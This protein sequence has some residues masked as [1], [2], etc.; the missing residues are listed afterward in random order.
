M[1]LKG[2]WLVLKVIYIGICFD[3]FRKPW[4]RTGVLC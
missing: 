4:V 2:L 1:N 3:G